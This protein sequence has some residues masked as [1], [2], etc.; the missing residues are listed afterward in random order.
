MLGFPLTKVLLKIPSAA[1]QDAQLINPRLNVVP[2][3]D[4]LS[5]LKKGLLS[6]YTSSGDDDRYNPL[7]EYQVLKT[8]IFC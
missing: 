5:S 8:R 6:F 3:A 4:G 2:T 7:N 1:L